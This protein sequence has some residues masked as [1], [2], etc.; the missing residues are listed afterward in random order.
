M[1]PSKN[2]RHRCRFGID[3]T[4]D[5]LWYSMWEHGEPSIRINTFPLASIFINAAMPALLQYIKNDPIL[6]N[7]IKAANFLSTSAGDLCITLIYDD[8]LH[9]MWRE[10][11]TEVLAHL[12]QHD[13]MRTH[14]CNLVAVIGRSKGVKCVIGKEE[15]IERFVLDS[16]QVLVYSQVPDGFSNPNPEVNKKSLNWLCDVISHIPA[17]AKLP[18]GCSL[19]VATSFTSSLKDADPEHGAELKSFAGDSSTGEGNFG[20]S[21]IESTRDCTAHDSDNCDLLELYCGNGNHTIA[22]A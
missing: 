14:N 2:Y 13:N 19:P 17:L 6:R 8:P 9:D 7:H 16:G 22:L 10:N 11:G 1:S 20:G 15:V 5:E 3:G 12:R 21:E 18:N 4:E